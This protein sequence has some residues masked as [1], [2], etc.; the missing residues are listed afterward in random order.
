MDSLINGCCRKS[1]K[2]RQYK[3]QKEKNKRTNNDHHLQNTTQNTKD[4][5][6]RTPLET[7]KILS[8]MCPLY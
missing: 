4:R 3:G 5:S 6:T 8:K 7:T 2:K 1:K